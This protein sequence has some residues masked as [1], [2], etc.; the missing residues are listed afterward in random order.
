MIPAAMIS[1]ASAVAFGLAAEAIPAAVDAALVHL[2]QEVSEQLTDEDREAIGA[3]VAD[4]AAL[5]VRRSQGDDVEQ[6]IAIVIADLRLRKAAA[7][8]AAEK[9]LRAV[10]D[11]LFRQAAERFKA[12]AAKI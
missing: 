9:A 10:A 4:L 11:G 1:A 7:A 2:P 5:E 3:S 6:E 8:A 12:L